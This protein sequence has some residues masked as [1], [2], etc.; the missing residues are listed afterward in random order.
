MVV[1]TIDDSTG[2]PSETF[3]LILSNA[4]GATL[5]DDTGVAT[6]LDNDSNN[7]PVAVDDG[8]ATS[9]E[10]E[11]IIDVL[12]ND[13]DSD[14]DTLF[15]DSVVSPT[16]EGGTVVI[17]PDNTLSYTS[18]SSFTGIDTF[19]YTISDGQGGVSTATV[20][21]E[22]TEVATTAM[23]VAN[24]DFDSRKGGRDWRRGL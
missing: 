10:T 2:E 24:I 1:P 22:V 23:F 16:S 19:S 7:A 6:I 3:K 21:V 11:E 17:N 4:S 15:V 20:T 18:A 12:A 8:A 14:G 13:F 9:T 5:L